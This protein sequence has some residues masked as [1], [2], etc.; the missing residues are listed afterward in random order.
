MTLTEQVITIAMCAAGTMAT[1]FIPFLVF[2]ESRETPDY[3]RYLGNALP[4]AI[5]GMLVVYCLKDVSFVS[6]SHGLPEAI[7][8]IITV[9]SYKWKHSMLLSIAGGAAVYMIFIHLL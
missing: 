5:F 2:R 7:G 9:L 3:I 1:R 4:L 6:G 8:I